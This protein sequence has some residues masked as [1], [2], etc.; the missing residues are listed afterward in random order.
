MTDE[1]MS[2][3]SENLAQEALEAT[4]QTSPAEKPEP[5]VPLHKVTELRTRAQQAE[6]T[7]ARALGKLEAIEAAQAKSAPSVQSPLEIEI[8]RQAAEGIAQEDMTVSP[9]VVRAQELHN[10]Q[11]ANQEAEAIKA[12]DLAAKQ[13]T[14][15]AKAMVEHEDWSQVIAAGEP[16]LTKG[17]YV[18]LTAAGVDFGEKA[19]AKCKDAIERNKPKTATAPEK[20]PDES[21]AEKKAKEEAEKTRVLSQEEILAEVGGDADAVRASQL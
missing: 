5:M 21:E 3:D 20:K 15:K 12:A 2:S 11:I 8:A 13:Q 18:D 6:I 1:K 19:Y 16:F 14:S 7:A 10:K 4:E 17:E 9:A